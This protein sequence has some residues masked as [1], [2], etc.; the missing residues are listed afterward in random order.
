MILPD[1]PVLGAQQV[2]EGL[3][4]EIA[5]IRIAAGDEPFPITIS[6]GVAAAA[7]GELDAKAFIHRADEALYGAKSAGRNR[8][9]VAIPPSASALRSE[10]ST[11]EEAHEPSRTELRSAGVG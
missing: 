7:P 3:R 9:C 8:L 11:F 4:Q 2:A 5:K 10:S 6:I 1:T